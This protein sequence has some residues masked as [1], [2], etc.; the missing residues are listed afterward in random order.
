MTRL[1]GWIE[2][3]LNL[4]LFMQKVLHTILSIAHTG[5]AASGCIETQLSIALWTLGVDPPQIR[6]VRGSLYG[7]Y[8][9]SNT[10]LPSSEYE[11]PPVSSFTAP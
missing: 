7:A 1:E 9:G 5:F 10:I 6:T 2:L 3:A 4:C 11:R 8:C